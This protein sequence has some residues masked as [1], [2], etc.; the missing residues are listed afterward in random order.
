MRHDTQDIFF[1]SDLHVGHTNVI[2]YDGRPFKTTEEMHVELIKRWN[3]VVGPDSI[4]YFLGDLSFTRSDLTK[5]FVF[6][7]NGKIHAIAGNH[8][9]P[10]DLRSLGRFEEVHDYGTEIGVYDEDSLQSRGSQ[11]Y[12]KIVMA[13]YPILSWNKSHYGA[14]HIHGHC[15]GSLMKTMPD[16]YKRKVIDVGCNTIDYTPISYVQVKAIMD[17]RS[18]NNVDHHE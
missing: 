15:H 12:Q 3:S 18:I 6:Q 7:L 9:K 4:V 16:Y 5:W 13:H 8:D 10:K 2:K 11:G 1:I 14:W 17:K